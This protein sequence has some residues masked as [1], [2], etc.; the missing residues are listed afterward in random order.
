MLRF[1]NQTERIPWKYQLYYCEECLEAYSLREIMEKP[2]E[3]DYEAEGEE[4]VRQAG[5]TD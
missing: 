2:V 4:I 3:P 5:C 1:P